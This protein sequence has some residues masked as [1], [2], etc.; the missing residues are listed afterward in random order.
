[1]L[2]LMRARNADHTIHRCVPFGRV[3]VGVTSQGA[4]RTFSARNP[5]RWCRRQRETPA[6]AI[7]RR[8]ELSEVSLDA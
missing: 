7:R 1:M 8:L 3:A 5:L 2:P 4:P 6:L